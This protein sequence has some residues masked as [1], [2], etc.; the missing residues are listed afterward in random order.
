MTSVP[1]SVRI[2]APEVI[3]TVRSAARRAEVSIL[4]ASSD[5]NKKRQRG[6]RKPQ[7]ARARRGIDPTH[8]GKL[9]QLILSLVQPSLCRL[10]RGCVGSELLDVLFAATPECLLSAT[11]LLGPTLVLPATISANVLAP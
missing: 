6:P 7:R 4:L 1:S 10:E 9:T 11:I 5:Y 2:D 8:Q 3:A